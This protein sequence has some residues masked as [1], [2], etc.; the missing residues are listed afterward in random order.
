MQTFEV[1]SNTGDS[2]GAVWMGGAA[3]IVDG[4]GNIW[5]ATGNSAFESATDPYDNSDGVLELSSN[6]QLEQSF[7]PSHWYN[8]NSSDFD[9]GSSSPALMADGLLL[10]AGKSQI[11][12]VTAARTGNQ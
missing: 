5:V 1:A 10:Q 3:P 11:A 12:Y 4:S 8:D 2:Q 9:L 6:L 7:A